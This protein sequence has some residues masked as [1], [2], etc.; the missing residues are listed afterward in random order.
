MT[1]VVE[2]KARCKKSIANFWALLNS[3]KS[4][5]FAP[6]PRAL[7]FVAMNPLQAQ[8]VEQARAA[9]KINVK[10]N[11]HQASAIRRRKFRVNYVRFLPYEILTRQLVRILRFDVG[12]RVSCFSVRF[13]GESLLASLRT[14]CSSNEG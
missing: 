13:R 9:S 6:Q 3:P 11:R 10:E 12:T 1:E 8:P 14:T 5:A 2:Y 4:S 7:F